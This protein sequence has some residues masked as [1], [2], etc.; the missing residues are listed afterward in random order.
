MQ[1]LSAFDSRLAD[2]AGVSVASSTEIHGGEGA[3]LPMLIV[4]NALGRA[5]LTLQGAHLTS[6]VPAGGRELLW[7]S[8]KAAFVPGKAVRGGIPLCLP[9]F[10]GHPEGKPAHGFGRNQPWTLV[11]A[12]ALSDGTT[13]VTLELLP[14]DATR[15][16]WPHD[17]V[18]R[19]AVTVGSALTLAL[20]VEHRGEV[21]VPFSCALHTYFAVPDVTLADI[22]GLDGCTYINT[23]GGANT[24]H[25]QQGTLRLDAPTDRVYLDVPA[26]QTIR[27]AQGTTHIESDTRSAVVWNPGDFAL[28]IADVGEAYRHFVCVERGDVFDDA[29]TLAPGDVYE[30][31]LTLSFS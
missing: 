25:A 15:A 8:P 20:R 24:R 22:D 6:F 27:T 21:T 19:L 11:G 12:E 13:R 1:T 23:V 3:G 14:N 29:L 31:W 2:A 4:E 5:E 30:K 26:V 10:G 9:W 7:L 28:N 16:L 18:F 17:F